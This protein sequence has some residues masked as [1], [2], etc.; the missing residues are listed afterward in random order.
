MQLLFGMNGQA[1][2][3]QPRLP[4]YGFGVRLRGLGVDEARA[5]IT[6]ALAAEGF[7]I[8][9]ALDFRATLQQKLG[10]DV[11]PYLILSAC[12]PK[13]AHRALAIEPY[14]GLFLPCNVTLWPDG[15][16]V[17]VTIA[18]PE[19]LLNVI[20]DARLA[21]IADEAERRLRGALDRI[22]S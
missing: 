14:V 7:G 17:V 18:S 3:T 10:V 21:P 19:A 9:N 2:S 22:L 5:R 8:L 15:D 16:D 11:G 1:E 12:N 6:E 4:D 20:G 13:L